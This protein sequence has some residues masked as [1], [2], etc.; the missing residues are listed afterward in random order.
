MT[1]SINT[2]SLIKYFDV[3]TTRYQILLLYCDLINT[4]STKSNME[5]VNLRDRDPKC[6]KKGPVHLWTTVVITKHTENQGCA[7]VI[8]LDPAIRI[9]LTGYW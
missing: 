7:K 3:P 5:L 4:S 1:P 8:A 6:T 2:N 9:V